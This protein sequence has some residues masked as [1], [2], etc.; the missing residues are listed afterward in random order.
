[1]AD[2]P[3]P[4]YMGVGTCD[5]GHME[6]RLYSIPRTQ[7]AYA[8]LCGKCLAERGYEQPRAR[9]AEDIEIVDGELAWKKDSR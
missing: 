7:Y 6:K 4:V 2:A 3:R 5:S 8:L 1:V 9:T